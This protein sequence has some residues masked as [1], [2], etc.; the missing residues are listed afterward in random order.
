LVTVMVSWK[1][2]LAPD[3]TS[4]VSRVVV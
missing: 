1:V 2:V 4:T 3:T